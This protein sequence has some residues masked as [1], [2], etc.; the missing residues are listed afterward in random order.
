MAALLGI[1][2]C[3]AFWEVGFDWALFPRAQ[4]ARPTVR[5]RRGM[6]RIAL[7]YKTETS[8]NRS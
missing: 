7:A 6:R 2:I 5:E 3:W 1:T 8:A 4:R